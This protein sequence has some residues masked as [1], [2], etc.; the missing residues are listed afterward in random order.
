MYIDALKAYD[1]LDAHSVGKLLYYSAQ[2]EDE[3]THLSEKNRTVLKD[4]LE[5]FYITND[6]KGKHMY[7]KKMLHEYESWSRFIQR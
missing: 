3:I 7:L 2:L 4:L 1:T 6:L 5:K